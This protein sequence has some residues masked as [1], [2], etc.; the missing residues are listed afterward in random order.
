MPRCWVATERT[1]A[2]GSRSITGNAY[3]TGG[4][5]L[6]LTTPECPD[7]TPFPTT[8]GSFQPRSAGARDGFITKLNPSGSALVYSTHLGGRQAEQANA[9]AL[10][11]AGNAYVTGLTS[12]IPANGENDFPT[13]NAFKATYS[14]GVSDSFYAKLNAAGSALVYASYLSGHEGAKAGDAGFKSR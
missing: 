11:K 9:I 2:L 10:D 3:V 13:V 5:D 14:G 7:C 8:P 12:G 1:T 6:Q 4:T